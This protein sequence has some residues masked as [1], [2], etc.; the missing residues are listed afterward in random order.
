MKL[1]YKLI[2][3]QFGESIKFDTTLKEVN[4][5]FLSITDLTFNDY[6]NT[7]ISSSR[8]QSIYSWVMTI[9]NSKMK[10]NQK[11]DL[12]KQAIE[13][14]VLN[15]GRKLKLLGMLPRQSVRGRKFV[16]KRNAR[17]YISNIR[18]R[19]LKKL[20]NS[21]FDFLRLIR[22][23]EELNSAFSNN[24]YLSVI[25]L[26][27]AI[28]D[29]VPPIFGL[30][31]FTKV[32]NNYGTKSFKDSMLNL[33]NSSR[34]ISDAYLHTQI[35]KTESLPTLTQVDFSNDLDVLL[36]EIVRIVSFR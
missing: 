19:D 1:N 33:N 9:G 26:T 18:I 12:I 25:T 5:V 8:S 31:D 35:R 24:S 3:T 28:L 27:R 20:K 13:L 36:S 11:A 17:D 15:E 16:I 22:F 14:L 2:A 4:R 10:V 32:A 6:P 7:A 23:C 34:K 30:D 21:K 29:H